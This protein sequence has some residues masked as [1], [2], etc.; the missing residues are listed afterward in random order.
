MGTQYHS[1]ASRSQR[2]LIAVLVIIGALG[3]GLSY[4]LISPSTLGYIGAMLCVIAV[5]IGG[6]FLTLAYLKIQH[7]GRTLRELEL[8]DVDIMDQPAF[9]H[10]IAEL[11]KNRGYRLHQAGDNHHTIAL[12]AQLNTITT[13]IKVKQSNGRVGVDVVRA[14]LKG[15]HSYQCAHVMLI[16]NASFTGLARLLA[17]AMGCHLV[18]RD[19]LALWAYEFKMNHPAAHPVSPNVFNEQTDTFAQSS[20]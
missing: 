13:A 18:G 4:G 20:T 1:T 10:Y 12:I 8:D 19:T 15:K 16:T 2:D 11:L 14:A 3:A 17:N 9:E 6:V 7:R 5:V